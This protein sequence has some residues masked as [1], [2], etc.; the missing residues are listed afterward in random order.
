MRAVRKVAR[1]VAGAA[2]ATA[3]S[4]AGGGA[5]AANGLELAGTVEVRYGAT[6]GAVSAGGDAR[7]RG[8]LLTGVHVDLEARLDPVA[9]T[10]RL[11]PSLRADGGARR[12]EAEAG[13]SEAYVRL[14]AGPVDASAGIERLALETARLS[15]P[16]Q[17]DRSGANGERLGLPG[18]RAAAYLGRARIRA[19]LLSDDG[20]LGGALSVRGDLTSAQVEAHV[21][22]LRRWA[23]GAGVS[24]TVGETVV[25]GEGWLLSDPWR[26]RGAVGAS[27]YAGDA[28]WTLEAAFAPP[29]G[30]PGGSGAEATAQL[31]GELDL[32]LAD[33]GSLQGYAAVAWA[34]SALRPGD[35]APVATLS[36]LWRT[37]DPEVTFE[38]GPSLTTGR[39]ATRYALSARVI[40][41]TG[42]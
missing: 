30:A 35:V 6:V 31:A 8:E 24:G 13:L 16:F 9:L 37:G 5:R 40:A 2:L 42:F 26:A 34:G 14:R 10:V 23:L 41:T 25:Y 11:D 33:G 17:V 39:G 18:I 29:A 36:A 28:L 21:L 32:P 20:D 22:Y 27:G 4:C 15:V 12:P 3:V 38:L 19:A 7:T 1:L